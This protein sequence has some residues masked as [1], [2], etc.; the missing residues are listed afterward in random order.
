[1]SAC[2]ATNRSGDP[3]RMPAQ[4]GADR[5]FTHNPENAGRLATVAVSGGRASGVTRQRVSR[6]RR[7]RREEAISLFNHGDRCICL[8]CTALRMGGLKPW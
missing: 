5:C 2:T 6:N 8:A 3:C 7:L 1:M 4:R